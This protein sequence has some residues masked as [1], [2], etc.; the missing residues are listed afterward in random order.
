MGKKKIEYV[1]DAMEE[2]KL[3]IKKQWAL[4]IQRD[5][6]PRIYEPGFHR[7]EW[8]NVVAG[9]T[10]DPRLQITALPYSPEKVEEIR[11]RAEEWNSAGMELLELIQRWAEENEES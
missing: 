11:K 9:L 1:I 3:P 5:I 10:S 8:L 4:E 7:P 6:L 2:G